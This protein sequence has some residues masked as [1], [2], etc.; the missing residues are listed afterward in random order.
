M[1]IILFIA[2][3]FVHSSVSHVNLVFIHSI[4]DAIYDVRLRDFQV[5]IFDV[6]STREWKPIFTKLSQMSFSI[7]DVKLYI[8]VFACILKCLE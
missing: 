4:E 8:R 7:V 5:C 6:M 2:F 1:H 3:Y